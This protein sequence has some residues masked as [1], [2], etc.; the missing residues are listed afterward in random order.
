MAIDLQAMAVAM[1]CTAS[2][3]TVTELLFPG[4]RKLILEEL[5]ELTDKEAVGKITQLALGI[6][7][8]VTR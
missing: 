5:Q 8:L 4:G 1:G 6:P 7:G 3:R 2:Q